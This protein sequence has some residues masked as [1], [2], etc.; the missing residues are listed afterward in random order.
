MSP[1]ADPSSTP[2]GSASSRAGSAAARAK[3][4]RKAT[5]KKNPASRIP[6]PKRQRRPT[7]AEVRKRLLDAALIVFGELGYTA[8]SLDIV[9]AAAGL[10][11]GAVYSN[12]SSKDELYFAMIEDQLERRVVETNFAASGSADLD[13]ISRFFTANVFKERHWELVWLEYWARVVREEDIRQPYLDA[14]K[15]FAERIKEAFA[16]VR[17]SLAKQAKDDEK[18]SVEFT[19]EELATVLLAVNSGLTVQALP[20][21]DTYPKELLGKVLHKLLS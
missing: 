2:S 5:A 15:Q 12:F 4:P 7:R 9:A 21:P 20:S 13:E 17:E 19:E 16:P 11:K 6:I 8:A 1:I 10:T 3:T 18:A 14:R